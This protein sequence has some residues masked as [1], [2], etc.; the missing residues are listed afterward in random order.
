MEWGDGLSASAD[1]PFSCAISCRTCSATQPLDPMEAARRNMR[2]NLRKRFYKDAAAG[3]GTPFPVLLDGRAV[4]NAGRWCTR[5]AVARA[6]RS[7]RRRMERAGRAHRSRHHAAD[8][9]RQ[10]DHRWRVDRSEAG[11]GR[12]REI[13]RL[14]S[15]LLSRRLA[16]RARARTGAALGPDRRM[17][18]RRSRRA[19]HPERG[20]GVRRAAGRRGRCRARRDPVRSRGGS[21]P[22]MSSR[23]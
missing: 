14:R 4:E 15:R 13:S 5:R 10:R 7:D 18:A 6:W 19:L 17:G 2:P 8:A 23:R 20:R 12:D 1:R 22:R 3:E 16:R 11:R 9:A 21:A